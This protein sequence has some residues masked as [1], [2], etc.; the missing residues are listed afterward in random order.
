VAA[1][2]KDADVIVQ[3][4]RDLMVLGDL[5]KERVKD[6]FF[7]YRRLLDKREEE[8]CGSIDNV[9][10]RCEEKMGTAEQNVR[11]TTSRINDGCK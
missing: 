5:A 4:Q 7:E 9:V 2:E 1:S 3:E 11:L 10:T 6:A 8:I